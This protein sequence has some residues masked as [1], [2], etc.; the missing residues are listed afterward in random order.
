MTKFKNKYRIE[1][2]RLQNWDYSNAGFYFITI[3]VKDRKHLLGKIVNGE[4]LL[5][6]EGM[7]V[8]NE[9]L[10]MPNYHHRVVM[11]E[12]VV[13]PNHIHLLIELT[14]DLTP[15]KP[16]H[17][18]PIHESV[19]QRRNMLIPKILGKLQM[20]TSKHI[21]ILNNTQGQKNWQSNYHDHII[22]NEQSYLR[23]KQYIQNNPK[24]W[25]EDKFFI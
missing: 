21:N 19:L 20:L 4:M 18:K 1:S 11:D 12:W 15:V 2:N 7:I 23:I 5:S 16:I 17:V 25:K 6:K 14:D 22:R 13:M 9:I 24:N 10:E 3:C 8:K